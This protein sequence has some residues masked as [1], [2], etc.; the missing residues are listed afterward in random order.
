MKILTIPDIH[1]KPWIFDHADA[2]LENK[3]ADK[4]VCLMD[5][6]DDW[7]QQLNLDLYELTYDRAIRFAKE[8]PETLWCYG[9]H[10]LS[11]EWDEL[12]TGY[13]YAASHLVRKKMQE[14]RK[15]LVDY[16]QLAYIH[17][18]DN[19][20]FSHGGL[21]YE[22]VRNRI[23]GRF[24]DDIDYVIDTI[25]SFGRMEMWQDLSP[26]WYRPQYYKGKMFQSQKYLQVV[27]H[28][29]VE[30]IKK[31]RN[32][33][34][35]DVFSTSSNGKPIGK[36]QFLILDTGTGKYTTTPEYINDR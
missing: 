31:D 25:N 5:I 14:L 35:C 3:E 21:A 11:Y 29:P 27:G 32:V 30:E 12:E 2:I 1:L 7:K 34:S 28:T 10:D 8:H 36:P 16:R 13:S 18:I 33:I 24:H 9:N 23:P 26:I 17:R 4:A 19:V 22:F 6:A 20:L 15:A